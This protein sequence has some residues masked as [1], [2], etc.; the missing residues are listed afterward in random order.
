M[1]MCVSECGLR[2]SEYEEESST[3]FFVKNEKIL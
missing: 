1:N 2:V 3:A